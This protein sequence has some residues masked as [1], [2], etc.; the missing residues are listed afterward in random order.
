MSN[1]PLAKEKTLNFI[2]VENVSKVY[3]LRTKPYRKIVAN[4]N[5]NL[6][7]RKGNTVGFFGENGSGKTT[8]VKQIA[9]IIKPTE[10]RIRINDL[11]ST[12]RNFPKEIMGYMPQK[13]YTFWDLTIRELL[14][15]T[16]HMKGYSKDVSA[17]EADKFIEEYN[18]Q[19]WANSLFYTLSGGIQ[20]ITM[21]GIAIIGYSSLIILDEPN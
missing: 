9:G 21:F 18:L 15:R 11:E 13:S 10:G 17:F 14:F 3:K 19:K 16:C 8:L 2:S 20:R 12:L 6:H 1:Y 7:I 4:N 5:I